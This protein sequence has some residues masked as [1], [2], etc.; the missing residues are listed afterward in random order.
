LIAKKAWWLRSFIAL[1]GLL[2]VEAKLHSFACV[3]VKKA[4]SSCLMLDY[5]SLNQSMF[6]ILEVF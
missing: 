3:M 4:W 5:R 6:I 1:E 2:N